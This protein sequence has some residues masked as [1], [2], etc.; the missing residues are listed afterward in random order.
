M[1]QSMAVLLEDVIGIARAAGDLVMEVYR[2]DFEV[3]GKVDTSTKYPVLTPPVEL[4][5]ALNLS[6]PWCACVPPACVSSPVV[7]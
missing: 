2:S 5:R 3:R 4:L 1:N 6:R 7:Q